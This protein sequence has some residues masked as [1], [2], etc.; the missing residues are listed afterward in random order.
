V[1]PSSAKLISSY[2]RRYGVVRS[3]AAGPGG[4]LYTGSDSMNIQV[5]FQGQPYGG[6]HAYDGPNYALLLDPQ[7]RIF[8]ANYDGAVRAWVREATEHPSYTHIATLPTLEDRMKEA[9]WRK[10]MRVMQKFEHLHWHTFPV[11]CICFSEDMRFL[12]TGSADHTIKVW[13]LKDW[14]LVDCKK[15]HKQIVSAVTAGCHRLVFSGSQDGSLIMWERHE[16]A[17]GKGIKHFP[18][19]YLLSGTNPV[20]ALLFKSTEA[21]TGELYAGLSDGKLL[22]WKENNNWYGEVTLSYHKKAVTCVAGSP[23]PL[24]FSGSEDGTICIWRREQGSRGHTVHTF[25]MVLSA[26]EGP[27]NCIVAHEDWEENADG[28]LRCILYSGSQDKTL[29]TWRIG[30]ASLEDTQYGR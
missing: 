9:L 13:R 21:G 7:G 23:G 18:V 14:K 26:H 27:V 6:F 2:E 25:V 17:R 20:N 8:A 3:M 16:G 4:L 19:Q 30:D 22:F 29:K 1:F 10:K 28:P 24:V 12:Y 5:W 15:E 11:T